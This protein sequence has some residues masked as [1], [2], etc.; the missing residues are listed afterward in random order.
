VVNHRVVVLV[1]VAVMSAAVTEDEAGEE[2]HRDDEHDP[3]DDGDPRG[4]LKDPRGPVGSYRFRGGRRSCGRVP[5]SGGFRCFTH[6]T[7]DEAVN[8]SGRYALLM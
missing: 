1:V 8:S 3:G 4:D 2:D 5:H 7:N 6:E